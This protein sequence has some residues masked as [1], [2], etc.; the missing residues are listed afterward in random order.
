MSSELNKF[1]LSRNIPA[2]VRRTIRQQCGFG[3]VICANPICDY[4][5]IDPEFK[6]ARDHLPSKMCLLCG[7]CHGDV[8]R[9]ITPKSEVKKRRGNPEAFNLKAVSRKFWINTQEVKVKFGGATFIDPKN[10]LN[11]NGTEILSIQPPEDFNGPPRISGQFFSTTGARILTLDN[12]IYTAPVDIWDIESKGSS[13]IFRE[14]RRK[15]V[16]SIKI[17]NG[18]SIEVSRVS[19]AIGDVRVNA[20]SEWLEI[21]KVSEKIKTDR[22]RYSG[23]IVNAENCLIIQDTENDKSPNW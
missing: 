1:G 5:H 23:T 6:D 12:N 8:N 16:L 2:P 9:G 4:E 17:V 20:S 14:A 21:C 15:I 3:C 10:V 22:L 19:M 7:S 11:I 13:L 18:E